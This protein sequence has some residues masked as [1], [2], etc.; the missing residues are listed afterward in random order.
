[1][2]T[3]DLLSTVRMG[4]VSRIGCP[5][6]LEEPAMR[7]QRTSD[8]PSSSRRALRTRRCRFETLEDRSLLSLVAEVEP[9]DSRNSAQAMP[10]QFQSEVT[11]TLASR[12]DVD[13]HSFVVRA[14]E[15]I[16]PYELEIAVE[17][18]HIPIQSETEPNNTLAAAQSLPPASCYIVEG[19]LSDAPDLD[20]FALQV[21]EGD[22]VVI[23]ADPTYPWFRETAGLYA[24]ALHPAIGVYNPSGV[25]VDTNEAWMPGS[26]QYELDWIASQS[27]SWKIVVSDPGDYDFDGHG[28]SEALGTY[29]LEI[30]RSADFTGVVRG[31]RPR[32]T[33]RDHI[34]VEIAS[35]NDA[36]PLRADASTFLVIHGRISSPEA[37][38]IRHLAQAID[39]YRPDDQVLTLDWREGAADNVGS[40]GLEGSRWIS[41][42]APWA[43][44]YLVNAGMDP[45]NLN[46][47]GHS[48]GALLAGEIARHLKAATSKDVQS[49][50][51]LEPAQTTSLYRGSAMNYRQYSTKAWA[52]DSSF[53]G[54]DAYAKTA[55]A[56]F[57]VRC[58]GASSI[59]AHSAAV[60]FF[61]SLVEQ[62]QGESNAVSRL[63]DLDR[64]LGTD[65]T[66][67][68]WYANS[69]FEGTIH[70]TLMQGHWVPLSMRYVYDNRGRMRNLFVTPDQGGNARTTATRITYGSALSNWVG[71]LNVH[72]YYRF[73][74]STTTRFAFAWAARTDGRGSRAVSDRQFARHGR[75]ALAR[76]LPPCLRHVLRARVRQAGLQHFLQPVVCLGADPRTLGG[77]AMLRPH[78]AAAAVLG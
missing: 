23:D 6:A 57:S 49:I 17:G 63:F 41:R 24:G 69:G 30:D 3:G 77:A 8:R 52:F 78:R 38:N 70:A 22:H 27:G 1:M 50:V 37:E 75:P 60:D 26:G 44:T 4:R 35:W 20:F 46:L 9:N 47:V 68:P 15:T 51:A 2:D 36:G 56:A 28:A 34:E 61:T 54:S 58:G 5:Q 16:G 40:L 71:E 12:T 7:R 73:N 66:A 19:S 43:A 39:G 48:W 21:G 45:A 32:S 25:L 55:D 42:V 14:R 76:R 11:G 74:L 10:G 59:A 18:P 62:N 33:L 53:L 64:L 65:T 13:F 72:D 67:P 31:T 29:V